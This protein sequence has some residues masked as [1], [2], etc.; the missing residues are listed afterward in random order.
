M[1][2]ENHVILGVHIT[3]RA[4]KA[5]RVQEVLT[6]YA[7]NIKTR[8]GLHEPQ[9]PDGAPNGL[10]LL[11]IQGGPGPAADLESRLT[12]IPGVFVKALVFDHP[13]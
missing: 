2:R 8:L 10:I 5:V 6:E 4:Q 12:S 11:E 9:G 1:M 7:G 3:E 13:E